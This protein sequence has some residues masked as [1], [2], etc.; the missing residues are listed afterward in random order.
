MKIDTSEHYK[1]GAFE[2]LSDEKIKMNQLNLKRENSLKSFYNQPLIVNDLKNKNDAI[3]V[4]KNDDGVFS[5][6]QNKRSQNACDNILKSVKLEKA[7]LVSSESFSNALQCISPDI[8]NS[9][10]KVDF[11]DS[12]TIPQAQDMRILQNQI[13]QLQQILIGMV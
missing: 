2:G 9:L 6:Y 12:F 3:L 10:H 5:T 8:I 11:K 13:S 4:L 7:K 1:Q